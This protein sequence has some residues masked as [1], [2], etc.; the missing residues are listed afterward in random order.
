MRMNPIRIVMDFEASAQVQ[1]YPI[2][3]GVAFTWKNGKITSGSKLIRHDPWLVDGVWS[4]EAQA[5]HKISKEEVLE[6]GC[7][8]EEVCAWLN[9]TIGA[10][11]AYADS[12]LDLGWLQQLFD[13][14]RMKPLFKMHH[15]ADVIES[16]DYVN[17]TC[18]IDFTRGAC[19]GTEKH[20]AEPDAVRISRAVAACCVIPESVLR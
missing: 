10:Q 20:R 15:I 5:V 18:L 13:A 1:G 6:K 12:E 19:S 11:D 17:E 16:A 4:S 9:Q 8:P 7:P 14:A 2:E 3:V